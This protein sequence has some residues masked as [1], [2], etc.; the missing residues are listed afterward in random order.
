M[1]FLTVGTQLPFERLV[2]TVDQWASFNQGVRVVAQIGQTAYQPRNL[3]V[4]STLTPSEYDSLLV[5][6]SLIVGHV[7]M[8]T[9]I[10]CLTKGK[11][12]LLLPRLK[13]YGEHRNDHQVDTAKKLTHLPSL[14][15]AW[16]ESELLERLD[17][18]DQFTLKSSRVSEHLSA[19]LEN[20][21]KDFLVEV[22]Q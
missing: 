8:G 19:H 12:M 1:I 2:E 17:D 6:S 18:V 14:R 10:S 16:T 21:L 9:I 11:P 15:V 7:G 5:G 22:E 13:R 20:G 3:E 4:V